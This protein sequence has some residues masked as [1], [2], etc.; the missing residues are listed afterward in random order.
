VIPILDGPLVNSWFPGVDARKGMPPTVLPTK[1]IILAQSMIQLSQQ[2][3]ASLQ[4]QIAPAD[5]GLNRRYLP[6]IEK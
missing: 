6:F 5:P 2:Q 4:S 3:F 1:T